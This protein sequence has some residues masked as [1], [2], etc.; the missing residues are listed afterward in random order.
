MVK[1]RKN[2]LLEQ[3]PQSK[4]RKEHFVAKLLHSAVNRSP[5]RSKERLFRI[6]IS[7]VKSRKKLLLEHNP[8]SQR[9]KEKNT[10]SPK[11]LQTAV[12]YC[13]NVE[14]TTFTIKSPFQNSKNRTVIFLV[15]D[16]G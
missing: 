11:L 6:T 7:M 1:S 16:I 14:V 2:L 8:Q 12:T 10:M 3:N 13:L 5:E 9:R 4:K 15:F